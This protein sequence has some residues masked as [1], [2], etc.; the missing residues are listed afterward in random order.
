MIELIDPR[1]HDDSDIAQLAP[2]VRDPREIRRIGF[3]SNEQEHL[4][5][6][7]FPGYTRVLERALH[8][9]LGVRDF[10][11]EIKPVLSRPADADM[12]ERFSGY[13]GVINGLAK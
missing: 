8:D 13:D 7:H 2:R 5:G 6:P 10:H 12:I 1:G 3:L 4:T 11:L 9:R